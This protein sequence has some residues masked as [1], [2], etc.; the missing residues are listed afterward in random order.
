[1]DWRHGRPR[2]IPAYV[3]FMGAEGEAR[4]NPRTGSNLGALL[5]HQSNIRPDNHSGSIKTFHLPP[6][7]IMVELNPVYR[8]Y[9]RIVWRL[10]GGVK[11][12]PPISVADFLNAIENEQVRQDCWAIIDTAKRN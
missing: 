4:C 12:N 10:Y 3:N 7:P 1:M 8:W 6:R 2:K 11:A 9:L 5:Q